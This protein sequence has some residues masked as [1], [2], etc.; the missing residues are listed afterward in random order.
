MNATATL[1][2]NNIRFLAQAVALLTELN[3]E[4]YRRPAPPYANS[5]IGAHLRH[6]L[7]HYHAFLAGRADGRIDYDAREREPRIET[8]REY[9][10]QQIRAIIDGLRAI[11][12]ADT[13]QPVTV[14]MDCDEHEEAAAA[15]CGSTV[16][17]EL[18]FLLSH[19]VHHNAIMAMIL[20]LHGCAMEQDFGVAPSTLRHQHRQRSCAPPRG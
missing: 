13:A 19:T 20:R 12:E 4:S 9:A 3:D 6:N 1:A 10:A 8:D 16:G 14:K 18:Q 5:G 2:D 15:W 17:R 11:P 7:D